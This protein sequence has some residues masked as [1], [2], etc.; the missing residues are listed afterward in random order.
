MPQKYV[1]RGG[2]VARSQSGQRQPS[3]EE[4][5]HGLYMLP[6]VRLAL[7]PIAERALATRRSLDGSPDPGR[8]SLKRTGERSDRRKRGWSHDGLALS[9]AEKGRLP[10]LARLGL[11]PW[12]LFALQQ[13]RTL[14]L[15]TAR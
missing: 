1:E 9:E 7:C 3:T 4:I 6:S 12:L 2:E 8:G 5:A 10:V 13:V 15:T 14:S 11:R